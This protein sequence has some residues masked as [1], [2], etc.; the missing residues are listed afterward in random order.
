MATQ[1]TYKERSWE[2]KSWDVIY[3]AET[4]IPQNKGQLYAI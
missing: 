1:I 3:F 2:N 4:Y